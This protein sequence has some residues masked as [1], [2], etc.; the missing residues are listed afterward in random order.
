MSWQEEQTASAK[1]QKDPSYPYGGWDAHEA[2]SASMVPH[3]PHFVIMVYTHER[4]SEAGYD[5]GDPSTTRTVNV[6]RYYWFDDKE[7]WERFIRGIWESKNN[8]PKWGGGD[9]NEFIFFQSSGKGELEVKINI[10][11]KPFPV[12]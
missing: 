12:K 4:F 11:V 5:S 8:K 2:K 10:D 6:N 9:D 7:E 3:T 1:K